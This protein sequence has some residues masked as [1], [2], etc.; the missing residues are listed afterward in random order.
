MHSGWSAALAIA[1]TAACTFLTRV[2][3]FAIFGNHRRVPGVVRY[4]GQVLPPAMIATLVIYCFRDVHALQDTSGWA[5]YIAACLVALL[6]LW[7]R[8]TLLSV[9]A[10]TL[11]YMV[12]IRTLFI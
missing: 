12:L 4:L 11:C 10:G 2:I 7:K 3:P 5:A 6:H 9:G 8:N 1:V